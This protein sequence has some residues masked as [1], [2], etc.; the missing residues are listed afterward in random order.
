MDKESNEKIN[1]D[2]EELKEQF[3]RIVDWDEDFSTG[4]MIGRGEAITKWYDITQRVMKL[5]FK[6]KK[7]GRLDPEGGNNE[8]RV[9]N[10]ALRDFGW[11]NVK[12]EEKLSWK[13]LDSSSPYTEVARE[14]KKEAMASKV[15]LKARAL[16]DEKFEDKYKKD[17]EELYSGEVSQEYLKLKRHEFLYL[18]WVMKSLRDIEDGGN[19]RSFIDET[20]D[21]SRLY[22]ASSYDEERALNDIHDVKV[23]S[24]RLGNLYS[25][26]DDF[27]IKSAYQEYIKDV[28]IYRAL[29][30]G[31]TAGINA[32]TT[33]TLRKMRECNSEKG[34][35]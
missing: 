30:I 9:F 23:L 19:T 17:I 32:N 10:N 14:W 12:S 28:V 34:E 5:L 6:I 13:T 29:Q 21:V 18:A 35:M 1:K 3:S 27:F 2:L 33:Q 15:S 24:E 7:E 31:Y 4:E 16:I 25:E 20:D 22:L 26:V 11:G 8:K